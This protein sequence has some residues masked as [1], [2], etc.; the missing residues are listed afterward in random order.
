MILSAET[1]DPA[2]PSGGTPNCEALTMP[3]A[4]CGRIPIRT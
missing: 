3:S 2:H 4:I 1:L